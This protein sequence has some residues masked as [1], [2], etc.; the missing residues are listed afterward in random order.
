MEIEPDTK[1]NEEN[2]ISVDTTIFYG[3]SHCQLEQDFSESQK[4][5]EKEKETTEYNICKNIKEEEILNYKIHKIICE[6]VANKYIASLKIIYK[7]RN[8]GQE[9]T[10]LE[11]PTYQKENN[12]ELIKIDPFVFDEFEEIISVRVW[13][14]DNKRLIGFEIETNKERIKKFGC[15][16]NDTLIKIDDFEREDKDN[17]KIIKDKIVIGFGV[18]ACAKSGVTGLYCYYI[19]KTLYALALGSGILYLRNKIKNGNMKVNISKEENEQMYALQKTC[20][21]SNVIFFEIVKYAVEK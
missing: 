20:N 9:I 3:D 14:E 13:V 7:N 19:S 5:T 1:E 6:V 4:K 10:L 11:T 2:N 17:K 12:E 16:E 21:S 8:D 18:N 15:G